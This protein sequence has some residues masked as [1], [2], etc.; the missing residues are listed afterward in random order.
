MGL[1]LRRQIRLRSPGQG[2]IGGIG[3]GWLAVAQERKQS[4]TRQ[5]GRDE[6]ERDCLD[7]PCGPCNVEVWYHGARPLYQ[8]VQCRSMTANNNNY[9][10]NRPW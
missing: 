10:K 7:G 3:E 8:T 2:L 9:A 4:R 1:A 6:H 5:Q